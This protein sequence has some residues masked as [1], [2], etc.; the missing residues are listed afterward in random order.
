ME[1]VLIVVTSVDLFLFVIFIMVGLN[2]ADLYRK[3]REL[4]IG[5]WSLGA[6]TGAVA[7]L[8]HL[9]S[10]LTNAI[11]GTGGRL[12]Y[13]V[14]SVSIFVC[15]WLF[16]I[17]HPIARRKGIDITFIILLSIPLG[18]IIPYILQELQITI[19]AGL[20]FEH[21]SPNFNTYDLLNFLFFGILYIIF[22]RDSQLMYNA[23][24]HQ[25]DA[26]QKTPIAITHLLSWQ[27]FAVGPIAFRYL[28]KFIGT[29]V[30]F[31]L[32]L[33]LLLVPL[34]TLQS[35]P[36]DWAR[37]G[38]EPLLLV[39]I[40]EHGT[41]IYSWSNQSYTPLYLE[42]ST[43]A[44]ISAMF[45]TF[46]DQPVKSIQVQF[47]EIALYS[48]HEH[49][50]L[51]ILLT[52]GMHDSFSKILNRIHRILIKQTRNTT[53][54]YLNN[55]EYPEELKWLLHHLLPRAKFSNDASTIEELMISKPK[56]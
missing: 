36:F 46:T 14:A 38:Y 26:S 29:P 27:L 22:A 40:D 25:E 20:I 41:P 51:S 18:Y 54:L 19:I 52:T 44:T 15:A 32:P 24:I 47:E 33:I 13:Q 4:S 1:L 43:L 49:D 34:N 7:S 28:S 56:I 8:L 53:G 11:S 6:I 10:L 23:A 16:G 30:Y 31:G 45:E 55:L 37:E 42:G 39:L 12:F 2:L 9:I 50:Y 35:R 5:I 21:Y 48:F 17:S 3:W